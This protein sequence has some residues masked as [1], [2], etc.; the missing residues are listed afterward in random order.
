MEHLWIGNEKEIDNTKTILLI[1]D[2]SMVQEIVSRVIKI[3]GYES[4]LASDW[5][6]WVKKYS[7]NVSTIVWVL[8][9]K[10]L[11][12]WDS[13]EVLVNILKINKWAKVVMCSWNIT[14]QEL[15]WEFKW[16]VWIIKKPF[17]IMLLVNSLKKYFWK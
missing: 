12:L 14:E 8:L 17:E 9:D 4:L 15:N 16:A 7:E 11:K 3:A 13:K 2:D 10:N 6:D 5:N 1:D